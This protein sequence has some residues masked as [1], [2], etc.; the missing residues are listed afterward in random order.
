MSDTS[1]LTPERTAYHVD[2]DRPVDTVWTAVRDVYNVDTRLVPGMVSVVAKDGDVRVVTF[3]NGAVVREQI[4]EIDDTD[5]RLV[6]GV[7]GEGIAFHRATMQVRL[8][9][10]GSTLL[11]SAEYLP[12][13]IGS[14]LRDV[15]THGIALMKRTLE[16]A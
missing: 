14:H 15:M 12:A 5:R 16:Q 8:R 7:L 2:I 13:E 6:Y 1:A 4:V 3:A 11:W 10:A 9:G